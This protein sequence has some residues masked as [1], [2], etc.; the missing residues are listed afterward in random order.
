[1]TKVSIGHPAGER[2]RAVE[3]DPRRRM[4][5]GVRVTD[6][7]LQ[8]AGVH[9]AVLEAGDGPPLVLLQGGI[10]CGGAY[11]A[12]VIARLAER[13]RLVVPDL[14]GLGESAPPARPDAF[15]GWFAAL[16]RETCPEPPAL[17]AH[18]LGGSLAARFAA[19]HAGTP[20]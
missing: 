14:P 5:A 13:F 4:L 7:R 1:M 2:R 17:V 10:E 16:L 12:P 15:A 6:R 18:S 3:A 20:P 11:W 9:T 8:V 19:A